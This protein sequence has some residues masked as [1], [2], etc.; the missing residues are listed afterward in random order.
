MADATEDLIGSN[1]HGHLHLVES[2][3][4]EEQLQTTYAT[5]SSYRV[6]RNTAEGNEVISIER[7]YPS[8]S[9]LPLVDHVLRICGEAANQLDV[10]L[11]QPSSPPDLE[12]AERLLS[13][14]RAVQELLCCREVGEGLLALTNALEIAVRLHPIPVERTQLVAMKRSL[15][16]LRNDPFVSMEEALEEIERIAGVGLQV[17][18]Q[19]LTDLMDLCGG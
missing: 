18:P 19:A 14:H 13:V 10:I 2:E 16:L 6:H 8:V 15:D 11:K 12:V 1:K 7:L 3:T 9:D 17:S 4:D 5:G